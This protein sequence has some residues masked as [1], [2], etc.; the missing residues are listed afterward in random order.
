VVHDHHTVSNLQRL[1]LIM[2]HLF[3]YTQR[4]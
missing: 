4:Q 2:G 1:F 3:V